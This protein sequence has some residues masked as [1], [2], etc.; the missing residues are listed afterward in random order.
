MIIF[1]LTW[2]QN[3][4]IFNVIIGLYDTSD[5]YLTVENKK[6]KLEPNQAI[7]F[8][9]SAVNHSVTKITTGKRIVMC[10]EYSSIPN[11]KILFPWLIY[12]NIKD[13]FGFGFPFRYHIG[14]LFHRPLI[15]YVL[16]I[17]CILKLKHNFPKKA[18]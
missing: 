1:Q 8:E 2:I 15:I 12:R 3:G 13:Y 18:L 17:F 6:I 9:G 14:L 4:K 16:S 10:V 5:A 7:V 11:D